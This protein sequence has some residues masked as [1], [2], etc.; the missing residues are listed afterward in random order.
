MTKELDD[1]AKEANRS[2]TGFADLTPKVVANPDLSALAGSIGFMVRLVQ[3]QS[4]QLFYRKFEQHGLSL[5]AL[6]TLG[7]INANPG[8]RHGVLADALMIKRPNFTKVINKLEEEGL[9]A[10]QA[11]DHDKRTTALHV[12]K[13]GLRMI[14]ESFETI[15]RY[16]R[17]MV[18]TLSPEEQQTLLALLRKLS[19]H[20]KSLLGTESA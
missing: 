8:I 12:T 7:A 1:I 6:T 18:T 3:L 9:I 5:G 15:T 17:E 16:H 11:P 14:E 10:R 2:A 13:K 20:I 19:R 4:F